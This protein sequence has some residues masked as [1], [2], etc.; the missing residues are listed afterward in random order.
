MLNRRH[1]R[2]KVLQALYAYFQ[3]DK[4]DL[5][6][7]ENE[8]L[9]SLN[10]VEELYIYLFDLMAEMH[11]LAERKIEEG[12]RRRIASD[13][14][15]NPNTKFVSNAILKT[16]RNSKALSAKRA[17]FKLSWDNEN[18]LVRLLFKHLT[19]ADFYAEYLNDPV[20]SYEQDKD[21]IIKMFKQIIVNA[22]SLQY[23]LE[24]KSIFW[25]DD[26]D[27]VSSMIIKTIKKWTAEDD[28]Y[29]AILPLYR[30]KEDIF[31]AKSLYRNVIS[32]SDYLDKLIKEKTKNWELERIA[33]MDV[34]V[35][36]LALTEAK[37]FKNIPTKVTMNEFI[38]IAK[39]YST[40]K[41]KSF[42]NGILDN[43]F[44]EMKASGEITKLGRG[45]ME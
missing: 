3:S 2:I 5:V 37:E 11:F 42:I 24:E 10:K 16:I 39:F 45:L 20:K 18:D 29:V 17:D 41:S 32:E 27:L 14:D 36:K 13:L 9:F 15:L 4:N 35:M 31:F 34:L 12:K 7:G 8:L 44:T 43:L 25:V 30:D 23:H 22:E 21:F 19:E 26:L 38:E 40:P 28:E 33:L 6:K 1:I